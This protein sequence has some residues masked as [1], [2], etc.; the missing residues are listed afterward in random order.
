MIER[1]GTYPESDLDPLDAALCFLDRENYFRALKKKVE[2]IAASRHG[3]AVVV[4]PGVAADMPDRFALRVADREH[5]VFKDAQDLDIYPWPEDPVPQNGLDGLMVSL[6][7]NLVSTVGT[8]GRREQSDRQEAARGEDVSPGPFPGR[9]ALEGTLRAQDG[10]FVF[11]HSLSSVRLRRDPLLEATLREWLDYFARDCVGPRSGMLLG[12]LLVEYKE[13]PTADCEKLQEILRR[14]CSSHDRAVLL[15]PL[16]HVYVDE[17][18]GWVDAVTRRPPL[19]QWKRALESVHAELCEVEDQFR[20]LPV[21]KAILK[22]AQESPM[23]PR[24]S[25]THGA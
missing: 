9:K 25:A 5:G 10:Y 24:W 3:S 14:L 18:K 12:L 1:G 13:K 22:Y 4:V 15:E 20:L 23:R 21:R 11:R 16:P 2:A 19:S 17:V 7:E 8:S 6:A